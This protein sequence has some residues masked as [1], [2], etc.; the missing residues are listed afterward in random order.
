MNDTH[1]HLERKYR[2]MMQARS[3]EERLKMGFS[4]FDFS[5]QLVLEAIRR[6]LP[7]ASPKQIRQELFL[8]FYEKDFDAEH[9]REILRRL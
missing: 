8:R 4:M 7:D 6:E 5:R 1:P 2:E 3:G 9:L